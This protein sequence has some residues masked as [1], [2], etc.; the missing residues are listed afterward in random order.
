LADLFYWNSGNMWSGYPAWLSFFRH[1]VGL[2][3][4][5]SKWDAYE[6]LAEI[7]PRFM[8][9]EFCLV[10]A[11]PVVLLKDEQH[12]PHCDDGPFCRWADGVALYAW[13][14]VYTPAWVIEH[15]E[16]ITA[17]AIA[18]EQ[19]AEVRRVMLAKM[20]EDRFVADGGAALVHRDGAG[21]LYRMADDTLAVRVDNA[22]LEADGTRKPY[23]LYVHPELRPMRQNG[24]AVDLGEPQALTARNAVASTFGLRGPDYAP[25]QES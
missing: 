17:A 16:R 15:P 8:H 23:W 25:E 14:G 13:Q 3:L 21:T 7:G 18:A 19:N 4:D 6:T 22:T 1:V 11:R 20:G 12:R 9:A 2:P 24:T 10:S 5:Y